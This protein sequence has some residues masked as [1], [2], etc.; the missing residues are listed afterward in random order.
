MQNWNE[1]RFRQ[2]RKTE[3]ERRE[4][5]TIIQNLREIRKHGRPV[6]VLAVL[7]EALEQLDRPVYRAVNNRRVP[8]GFVDWLEHQVGVT[9]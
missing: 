9:K 5:W 7:D 2:M 4:L 8:V 6:D 1:N 3:F